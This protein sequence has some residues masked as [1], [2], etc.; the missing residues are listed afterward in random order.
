MPGSGSMQYDEEHQNL[1]EQIGDLQERLSDLER[2]ALTSQDIKANKI[3]IG[4]EIELEDILDGDLAS[5]PWSNY[6]AD[7]TVVGFSGTPTL[8]IRYKKLGKLVFVN[9]YLDGTSDSTVLTFTLRHAAT[10]EVLAFQNPPAYIQ[11]DGV[12]LTTSSRARLPAGSNVVTVYK[13]AVS[14]VWT[15]SGQKTAIGQLVYETE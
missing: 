4:I 8:D 5:T 6:S 11:D 15:D 14:G 13:T 3:A 10:T 9:Y 12:V 1:I 2:Y 7:S